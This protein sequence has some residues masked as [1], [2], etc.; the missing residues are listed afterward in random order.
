MIAEFNKTQTNRNNPYILND[1]RIDEDL[2]GKL[3]IYD[4]IRDGRG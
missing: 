3:A 4:K 1:D 2:A